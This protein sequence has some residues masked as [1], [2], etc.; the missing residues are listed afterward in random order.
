MATN[1][2][3]TTIRTALHEMGFH[4]RVAA[5]KPFLSARYIAQ[6]L[7][8]VKAHKNWTRADWRRVIWTD[9]SSFEIG[10][11]SRQI[12]VWRTV[13]EKHSLDCLSPSFKSGRSSVMV[14]G[15][16]LADRKLP[17]IF[18]P[19]GRRTAADFVEIVYDAALGPFLEAQGDASILTLMEDGAPVHRSKAPKAWRESRSLKKLEWPANSPI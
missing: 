2:G 5:A 14:W 17:L 10:K 19:P 18:M 15:A 13:N 1:A 11:N 16:F 3:A 6:R 4:A 12:L 9:E 7:A 8:F